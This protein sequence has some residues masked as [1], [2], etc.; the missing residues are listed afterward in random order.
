M[1]Q[2]NSESEIEIKGDNHYLIIIS[3]FLVCESLL[4]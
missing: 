1:V 4:I 2:K 3:G